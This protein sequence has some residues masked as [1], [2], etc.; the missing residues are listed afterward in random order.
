M[1]KQFIPKSP[2]SSST[3]FFQNDLNFSASK[4]LFDEQPSPTKLPISQTTLAL[5][6]GASSWPNAPELQS[7]EG[8]S[9]SARDFQD[10]LLHKFRL[11]QNNLL[12]LFDTD[13]SPDDLDRMIWSFLKNRL[14]AMRN[15]KQGAEYLLIYYVGHGI[16]SGKNADL[17]L[18]IHRTRMENPM[19]SSISLE[20]LASTLSNC[21]RSLRQILVLD[22][23]FAGAAAHY[24]ESTS[25]EGT[26]LLCSS[27]A[28]SPS[29]FS[30]DGSS[31]MF[32]EGLLHVLNSTD[33]TSQEVGARSLRDVA[34]LTRNYLRAT[35]G[36]RTPLPEVHSPNQRDLDVA[37]CPLFP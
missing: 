28:K 9:N 35:Y 33:N 8:F 15:A 3:S 12:N 21:V 4:E 24:F 25:R 10:Y 31:T 32:T 30:P 6:L 27:S 13:M 16:F 26:S 19:S 11:P 36:E 7:S 34:Y 37:E 29:L 5:I 14:L 2:S 20:N 22:C 18:A 23:A 17:S 1:V